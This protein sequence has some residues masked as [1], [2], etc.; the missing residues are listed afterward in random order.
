[1]KSTVLTFLLAVSLVLPAAAQAPIEVE[2]LEAGTYRPLYAKG[3]DRTIEV[4]SFYLSKYAVTNRDFLAFVR[5]NPSW[6]RSRVKRIFAGEGY[7]AHWAGDLELG[8]AAAP[9]HPVVNV[10]WFSARAYANWRGM[11]LPTIAEWEYAA[12][13]GT[14][15]ADGRRESGFQESVLREYTARSTAAVRPVHADAP[16]YWGIHGLHSQVWEWVDDFNS[17]LVTGESR[18]NTDLDR[19]LFCGGASLG[20][21]DVTDYA[22]FVRYAM[23]SGLEADYT[24]SNLGF[25]LAADASA[26]L[27][28]QVR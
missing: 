14:M 18:N 19:G 22:A 4:G 7:L 25:R 24:I 8:P 10:S 16:N 15:H 20:A 21:S 13:A 5:A 2:R 3:A 1:M 23:R 11:R 6:R 27:M 9:N 12:A 26:D 17:S 28:T